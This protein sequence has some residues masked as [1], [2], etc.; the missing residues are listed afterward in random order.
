MLKR[1]LMGLSV[2]VYKTGMELDDRLGMIPPVRDIGRRN[3]SYRTFT[4]G[5][6][7]M[8]QF[9]GGD[10]VAL[11]QQMQYAVSTDVGVIKRQSRSGGLA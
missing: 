1:V 7:D 8:Q 9:T 10:I 6:Q 4:T 11:L 3:L 5:I 2:K